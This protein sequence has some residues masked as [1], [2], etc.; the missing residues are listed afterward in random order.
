MVAVPLTKKFNFLNSDKF[1]YFSHNFDTANAMA[2]LWFWHVRIMRER[3]QVIWTSNSGPAK[4]VIL[5]QRT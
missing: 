4:S 5:S 3:A 2:E 1:N